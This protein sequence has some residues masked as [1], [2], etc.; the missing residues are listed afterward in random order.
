MHRLYLI[1]PLADADLD[2]IADKLASLEHV[3]EVSITEGS[4]GLVVKTSIQKEG[5][6]GKLTNYIRNKVNGRF[7]VIDTFYKYRKENS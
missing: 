7:D 1:E 2:G 4:Y 5:D 6:L 3:Q